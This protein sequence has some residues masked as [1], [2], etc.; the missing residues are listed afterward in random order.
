M[1]LGSLLT[2]LVESAVKDP[3]ERV[4]MYE[5]AL[6]LVREGME[7]QIAEKTKTLAAEKTQVLNTRTRTEQVLSRVA[8]GK[9]IIDKEGRILMMNPAAERISGR[10]LSEMVGKHVTTNLNPLEHVLTLSKDMDLSDGKTPSGEVNVS[11]DEQVSDVLRH[12][13][14]LL[15]DD[16][17]RV[18]G[19]FATLPDIIKFKET[20]RMQD[21]FLSRVTHDLQS[22]LSSI[23]SALEML[24]EV[25][26]ERL[27]ED[28]NRF[29]NISLRNSRRLSEMIRGILD[30]SKLHE[31]KMSVHPAAVPLCPM[32][33]EAVDSL[34]PW[35]RSRGIT[36]ALRGCTPE[37]KVMAD[38]PRIVQV[39]VN[40]ISNAV[41][42]TPRGGCVTVAA[43]R[44]AV[45]HPAVVVGVRDTGPGISKEDMA[46]IFERFVQLDSSG[47]REGVGL[48]LSIVKEFVAL[49]GGKTWAESEPGH[50]ATFYFTLPLAQSG[51]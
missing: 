49:H 45:P 48:G 15:E 27:S 25:A 23:S 37:A 34:T 50:G 3:A 47:A 10:K 13:I 1:T 12:S 8:E 5:D 22:P 19:A 51:L 26:A 14:A 38:H 4:K 46:K 35:A 40:L 32:L 6:R 29:L 31:G 42:S 7:R 9:V 11:G 30:F 36:L 2:N 43:A 21:E 41:K 16:E 18:V 24:T 44:A 17:G 28:E 39:L 20:Q 33:E